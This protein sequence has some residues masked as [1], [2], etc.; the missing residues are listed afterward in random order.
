MLNISQELF[1]G[2]HPAGPDKIKLRPGFGLQAACL[3]PVDVLVF[4]LILLCNLT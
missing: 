4:V 1:D 2:D 3:T